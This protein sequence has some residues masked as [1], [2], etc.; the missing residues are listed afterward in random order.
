MGDAGHNL[1]WCDGCGDIFF[2]RDL[3]LDENGKQFWCKQCDPEKEHKHIHE[4]TVNTNNTDLEKLP[5]V[6]GNWTDG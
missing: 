6:Q 5:P 4:H 2:S 3:R 1:E